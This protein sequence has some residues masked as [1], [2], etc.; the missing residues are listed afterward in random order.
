MIAAALLVAQT[1]SHPAPVIMPPVTPRT[2]LDVSMTRPAFDLDCS[3]VDASMRRFA[4]VIEQRGGRGYVDPR[5]DDPLGRFRSTRLSFR[6]VEDETG[7]FADSDLRG[8]DAP[9]WVETMETD[10][11][12]LGVVRLRTF[13]TGQRGN[14]AAIVYVSGSDLR[15]TGFVRY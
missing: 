4:L 11:P 5:S 12:E 3:L 2:P 8:S 10:H 9:G 14:L 15:Y 1:V 7:L 6:I 13:P